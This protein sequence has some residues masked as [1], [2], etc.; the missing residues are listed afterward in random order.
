MNLVRSGRMNYRFNFGRVAQTLGW[1]C[2]VFLSGCLNSDPYAE[3]RDTIQ[4]ARVPGSQASKPVVDPNTLRYELS[5]ESPEVVEGEKLQF[6]LKARLLR[7]PQ[8]RKKWVRIENLSEFSGATFDESTGQFEWTPPLGSA[9]GDL[10]IKTLRFVLTAEP[11]EIEPIYVVNK[12]KIDIRVIR[13]QTAPTIEKVDEKPLMPITRKILA[14]ERFPI[15]F[16]V[17]DLSSV[18]SQI[19]PQIL[20]TKNFMDMESMV[21]LVLSCPEN[22][23]KQDSND[24]RLWIIECQIQ[25]GSL[26][27]SE[28]AHSTLKLEFRAMNRDRKLSQPLTLDL[29][30][31]PPVPQ[32]QADLLSNRWTV[33]SGMSLQQTIIFSSPNRAMKLNSPQMQFPTIPGALPPTFTCV[34]P[35]NSSG[36]GLDRSRM[37]CLFSWV[38]PEVD[39]KLS[40]AMKFDVTI[41][42]SAVSSDET[43]TQFDIFLEVKP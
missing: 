31:D 14:G 2:A 41:R 15:R 7:G 12:E 27:N 4:K 38:A 22:R 40:I 24:V 5:T 25:A 20:M 39:S 16:T 34:H 3:K 37:V 29:R 8:D 33:D 1:V 11:T 17:K 13:T 36:I 23:A 10:E 6:A 9:I 42:R 26:L 19:G 21:D 28:K 35:V 30:V 18:L 32:A 43:K